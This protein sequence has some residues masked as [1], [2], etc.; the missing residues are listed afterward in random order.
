MTEEIGS[1]VAIT[2]SNI[3]RMAIGM[4]FGNPCEYPTLYHAQLHSLID[5]SY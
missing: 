2:F 1:N 4:D 5:D 3:R